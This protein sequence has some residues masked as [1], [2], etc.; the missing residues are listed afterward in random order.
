[1]PCGQ[2]LASTSGHI[3]PAI[4]QWYRSIC[5][6]QVGIP[7]RPARHVPGPGR[8]AA[9]AS[10][11]L[12]STMRPLRT[13]RVRAAQRRLLHVAGLRPGPVGRLRGC[14]PAIRWMGQ[15]RPR[16]SAMP[17]R[18]RPEHSP[19]PGRW[20]CRACP[21]PRPPPSPPGRRRPEA[22]EQHLAQTPGPQPG[23]QPA[24]QR[25]RKK[26][27]TAAKPSRAAVANVPETAARL[28]IRLS[29]AANWGMVF[30]VEVWWGARIIAKFGSG[31][32][33]TSTISY[34]K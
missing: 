31:A 18:T 20:R 19:R 14:N 9:R 1:M 11:R 15:S 2:V 5:G 29:L 10:R 3:A 6:L 24:H 22:I 34:H 8:K 32:Y 25:R 33:L 30:R 26:V 17:P 13:G 28:Y 23:R 21:R 16:H 27:L 12:T 4:W 7:R